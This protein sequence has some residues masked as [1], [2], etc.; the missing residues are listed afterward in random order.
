[1]GGPAAR[2]V[3]RL[4]DRI[5]GSETRITGGGEN[6]IGSFAD[7]G[8]RD[9]FS[10]ARIVPG[11][12]GHAHIVLNDTN[13]RVDRLRALL[14]TAFEAVYQTDVHAPDEPDSIRLG[15]HASQQSNQIRTFMLFENQRRHVWLG[16]LAVGL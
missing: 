2:L 7:L 4:L 15:T 12:V 9:L 16:C 3:A 6:H 11:R 1:M 13:V 5:E 14:V 8:Q 10:L